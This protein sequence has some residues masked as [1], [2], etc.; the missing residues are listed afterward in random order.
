MRRY[1]RE[2]AM[3]TVHQYNAIAM[4]QENGT[5]RWMEKN[6]TEEDHKYIAKHA[7]QINSS[8]VETAR[9]LQQ[10]EHDQKVAEMARQKVA[11]RQKKEEVSR[12]RLSKIVLITRAEDVDELKLTVIKID[13]QLDVLRLEDK[14]ISLKSH[15]GNKARKREALIAAIKC[16]RMRLVGKIGDDGEEMVVDDELIMPSSLIFDN[17]R[18]RL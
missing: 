7:R 9:K 13:K 4:C 1:L 11:A 14:K 16:R 17:P 15:L 18:D 3:K 10:V 5:E 2:K 8:G 12:L 6:F